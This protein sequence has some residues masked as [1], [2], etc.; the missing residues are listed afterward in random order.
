MEYIF[1]LIKNGYVI[2]TIVFDSATPD[3]DLLDA[4]KLSENVDS[5][6]S[7]AEYGDVTFGDRWDGEK[8]IRLPEIPPILV[9]GKTNEIV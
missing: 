9:E 6:I 1:A 3:I 7:C 8:F 2:N 5:I 4:V